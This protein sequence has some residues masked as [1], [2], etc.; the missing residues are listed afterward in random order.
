MN[1]QQL[2]VFLLE[3]L[4]YTMFFSFCR[5]DE[6]P[7]KLFLVFL[8]S[9]IISFF[10]GY[11]SFYSYAF[12][13]IEIAI[14]TRLL[15]IKMTLYD[16]LVLIVSM[17]FKL[18]IEVMFFIFI[19][20]NITTFAWICTIGIV[21]NNILIICNKKLNEIYNKLKKLWLNNNFYIRY[22]FSTFLYLYLIFSVIY[23]I[24]RM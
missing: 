20:E 24:V 6:K 15:K 13:F 12:Y 5:K 1:I 3:I 4:Y 22:L 19:R 16:I 23:I 9:N 11:G 8:I 17:I 2:I 18:F 21:K 7:Y 10:I 14:L